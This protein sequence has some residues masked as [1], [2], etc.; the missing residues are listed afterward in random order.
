MMVM[1]ADMRD[2]GSMDIIGQGDCAFEEKTDLY[3]K[4]DAEEEEGK[5]GE[6]EEEE[7][8]SLTTLSAQ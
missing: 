7:E 6:V 2:Q 1:E 4:V 8:V 5:G 3:E